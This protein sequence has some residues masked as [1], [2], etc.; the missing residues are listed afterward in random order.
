MTKKEALALKIFVGAV[1]VAT[2]LFA[3]YYYESYRSIANEVADQIN[4]GNA[5]MEAECYPEALECYEKALEHEQGNEQIQS[6]MVKAYMCMAEDYGDTDEA[7]L[8][9]QKALDINPNNKTA[10]WSIANI[11][12][13][14]G[15]EDTMLDVLHKGY[16]DTLD[17]SMNEK[18]F[19]IEEER[20]R[21][22]AE[23]EARL[24]EEEA[25][26]AEEEAR[27]AKLEALRD[28]F[29]SKDY[30]ALK[31]KLREDE[32]VSFSEEVIGDNSYYSGDHDV[33]GNREGYGIGLY[34]NGYYYYGEYHDNMR[35]GHGVLLRA[36]Y[37]E[38]SSIGSFIYDGEWE[39][40]APNGQ[41]TATSNYYKDRIQASDFMTKEISGN[42]TDGLEDG[43]M[44]LVGTTR[45]GAKRT[46]KYR[47]SMG[48]AEKSSGEN[49][50]VKGQYIIAQTDDKSES[51]TSD[52][53]I[54]GVE[55]FTEE[56]TTRSERSD[57]DDA[58]E[59]VQEV[60]NIQ[61]LKPIGD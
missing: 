32:Y 12:E 44:T 24:A 34:E 3:A 7:I 6:A 60:Q 43:D 54:R 36:T 17:E 21:I 55:G 18:V 29:E 42:Y 59:D 61:N 46:F 56:D 22:A 15:D 31:E 41:G 47:A 57:T 51:L 49:S 33:D 30:D 50:G 25:E 8:C 1:L 52:G 38:S 23:E 14:R 35:S 19:A 45:G 2:I 37:S 26:R 58:A 20:A 11:Y 48:V 53:S 16:E 27:A 10:Y 9:Y 39:D 13:L 5:F 4:K 40:D 28:M